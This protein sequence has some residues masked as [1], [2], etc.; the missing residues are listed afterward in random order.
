MN[1][2]R[3]AHHRKSLAG[4]S[5]SSLCGIQSYHWSCLPCQ[6]L[7]ESPHRSCLPCQVLQESP[8]WSCLPCQVLQESPHWSCLPC[9][10]LQECPHWSCLPCQV[11]QKS[12]HWSCLPCQ[13]LQK[14]PHWCCLPCQV[15]TKNLPEAVLL[16]ITITHR[17]YLS[18]DKVSVKQ[19][20][21]LAV[22]WR[23]ACPQL[24]PFIIRG[25]YLSDITAFLFSFSFY[26]ARGCLLLV[27]KQLCVFFVWN[28]NSLN[29]HVSSPL[30]WNS[31]DFVSLTEKGSHVFTVCHWVHINPNCGQ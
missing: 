13:V 11:L 21:Q 20:C 31:D 23:H 25:Q 1:L 22:C 17:T 14:S 28:L 10:L 12:P 16:N 7:Q 18:P 29:Q 9:Q 27:P 3:S 4:D 26:I 2:L 8:H 30:G 19:K 24:S 6:V 15:L 5:T